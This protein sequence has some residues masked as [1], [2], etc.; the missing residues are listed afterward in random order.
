MTSRSN[1]DDQ[2]EPIVI[3]DADDGAP[4]VI[5]VPNGTPSN[6]PRSRVNELSDEMLIEAA[7]AAN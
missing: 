6:V 3:L 7:R 1:R 2:S 5:V 4:L